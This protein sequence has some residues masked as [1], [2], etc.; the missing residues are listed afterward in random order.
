[1]SWRLAAGS[2][3]LGI[4]LLSCGGGHPTQIRTT[5]YPV[6]S[7]WNARLASPAAMVGVVQ[8]TGAAWMAPGGSADETRVE[9]SIQN[10]VPG[11][12][13]PWHVHQGRCG[14]AGAILGS[15]DQYGILEIDDKGKASRSATLEVSFPRSGEYLVDV[16]ASPSNLGTIISCGN[17]APPVR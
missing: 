8:V 12:R 7:R 15:A 5:E 4:G 1:M 2:V 10:A 9:I 17:L 11:G 14:S 3:A 13:H 6:G 16:H